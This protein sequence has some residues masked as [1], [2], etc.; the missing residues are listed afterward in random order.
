MLFVGLFFIKENF[1][2]EFDNLCKLKLLEI[3]SFK[4]T[5]F[6][7]GFGILAKSE[8]SVTKC[9]ISLICSVIVFK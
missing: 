7:I 6:K 9:S 8:N 5:F 2:F 1:I 3:T 4:F